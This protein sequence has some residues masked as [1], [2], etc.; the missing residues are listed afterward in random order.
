MTELSEQ[1]K[2]RICVYCGNKEET[3]E[4]M[5]RRKQK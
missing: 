2:D 3:A 1:M 4:W 5:E